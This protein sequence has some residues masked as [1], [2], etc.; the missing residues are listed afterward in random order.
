MKKGI[1][2]WLACGMLLTL[3]LL[4]VFADLAAPYPAGRENR[5]MTYHPPTALH[6]IDAQGRWHARPFVYSTRMHFDENQRRIYEEDRSRMF[7]VRFGIGRLL[8]VEEPARLFLLGADAR[9]RD[10]FSRMLYGARV[11]LALG[12]AG[13]LLAAV[14]GWVI[15]SL[16]GYYGGLA[17][18]I[19]MR[20]AEFFIMIPGFYFLL[21][22]R[23]AL[24]PSLASWQVY[25][26]TV[27]VLSLIGWGG[28]AR[29]VRGLVLQIRE[30]EFVQAARML[31]AGDRKILTGHVLPHTLPYLAVLLSVSVPSYILTESALSLL[32]LGIQEPDVSWGS[33]LS[34]AVSIAHL[35]LHPWM[36]APGLALCATAWCFNMLGDALREEMPQ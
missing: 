34:D 8:S 23:S 21:A 6:W 16:S 3:V 31:G 18:Q 36:I 35:E 13:A 1:A 28:I 26:L 2:F 14:A 24:P 11:S 33:L 20:L 10:L 32:G 22:L 17:D 5:R 25:G 30:L 19:L 4:A 29:V 9:G 12:L 7:P 15:G 27:G